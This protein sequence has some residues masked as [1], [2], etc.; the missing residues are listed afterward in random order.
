MI[1]PIIDC[2]LFWKE[3]ITCKVIKV[4][5][6]YSTRVGVQSSLIE[7]TIIIN[8]QCMYKNS[9]CVHH[10]HQTTKSNL[11]LNMN[12]ISLIFLLICDSNFTPNQI[13]CWVKRKFVLL[14]RISSEI[15]LT[16]GLFLLQAIYHKS[17]ATHNPICRVINN[18]TNF[19]L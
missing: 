10:A 19:T 18:P 9:K 7:W 5:V 17:A 16:M 15:I 4:L 2:P 8:L 6:Q 14:K 1:E 13:R 3:K 12:G 11:T